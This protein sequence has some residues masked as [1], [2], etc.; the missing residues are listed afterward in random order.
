MIKRRHTRLRQSLWL[1]GRAH[2]PITIVRKTISCQI[3]FEAYHTIHVDSK[4]QSPW[5]KHRSSETNEVMCMNAWQKPI[6]SASSG[7]CKIK[8]TEIKT[9]A[10]LLVFFVFA[11]AAF[12]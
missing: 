6:N 4:M 9:H 7:V 2:V 1:S 10:T 5:C 11:L 8:G 3:L 12:Q